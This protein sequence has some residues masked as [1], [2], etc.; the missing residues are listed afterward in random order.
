MGR[1]AGLGVVE[2]G[3]ELRRLEAEG[4]CAARDLAGQPDRGGGAG[5]VRGAVADRQ[6]WGAGDGDR[7]CRLRAT[8]ERVTERVGAAALARVA[9]ARAA[10]CRSRPRRRSVI[11]AVPCAGWVNRRDRLGAAVD[12]GVVG[13]H[14]DRRRPAVRV[15]PC[16]VA[17]RDG[18]VVDGVD[19]DRHGR[20][21][22]VA[23]TVACLV[24]ERVL[25]VEVRAGRVGEGARPRCGSACRAAGRCSPTAVSGS[26]SASVSLP[27]TPLAA[28]TVNARVLVRRVRVGDR[29]RRVVRR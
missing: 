10:A 19:G 3:A 26:P 15:H 27:S 1:S 2:A 8:V 12:I 20:R 6:P 22:R 18:R 13:E 5:G 7:D 4:A 17:D 11:A 14:V 29:H 28:L 16:G 23:L 21:R 25:A 9:V 24:G